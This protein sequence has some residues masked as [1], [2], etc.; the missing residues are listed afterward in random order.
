MPKTD[1]KCLEHVLK[2]EMWT[3]ISKVLN[4][5]RLHIKNLKI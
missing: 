5:S 1:L 3:A 4:T 2:H